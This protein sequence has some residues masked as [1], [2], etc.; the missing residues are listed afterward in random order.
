[1]VCSLNPHP[2]LA[3]IVKRHKRLQFFAEVIERH[4]HVNHAILIAMQARQYFL[5]AVVQH[6]FSYFSLHNSPFLGL[7][8]CCGCVAVSRSRRV[9]VN[10]GRRV[11]SQTLPVGIAPV[12][13]SF[14]CIAL[15]LVPISPANS[16]IVSSCVVLRGV[17]ARSVSNRNAFARSSTR[18]T[19]V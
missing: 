16:L 3:A 15:L 17:A 12:L 6:V 10:D 11:F 18:Y 13:Y 1:M 4:W 7:P 9:Y 14:F 19:V 5:I 8:R 2:F